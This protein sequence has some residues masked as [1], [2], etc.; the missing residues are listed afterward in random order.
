MF[1]NGHSFTR[2]LTNLALVSVGAVVLFF[3]TLTPNLV[4]ATTGDRSKIDT[5]DKVGESRDEAISLAE[6]K[7]TLVEP[8]V[9]TP[10]SEMLNQSTAFSCGPEA[11][12]TW[13]KLLGGNATTEELTILANTNNID[14]TTFLN[15]KNAAVSKGFG[16][17]TVYKIAF[18]DLGKITLPALVYLKVESSTVGH[19]SVLTKIENGLYYFS[20]PLLGDRVS[21][22]KEAFQVEFGGYVMVNGVIINKP[23][24]TPA[25]TIVTPTKKERVQVVPVAQKPKPVIATDTELATIN[26]KAL[27]I[28]VMLYGFTVHGLNSL[29]NRGITPA[30]I[31]NTIR[32][33]QAIMVSISRYGVQFKYVGAQAILVFN[34]WGQVI[35]SWRR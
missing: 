1:S 13:I 7:V 11:L 27:P 18:A 14:G 16:N 9:G 26:G 24:Q 29:M 23:N 15:L 32:N 20:D 35:T 33:P 30:M 34:Q 22:T 28:G 3:C 6:T 4:G 12:G 25:P 17:A 2:R 19:Y 21:K 8:T 5:E 10:Q 31:L